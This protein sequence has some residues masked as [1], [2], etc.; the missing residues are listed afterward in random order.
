[1]STNQNKDLS[2]QPSGASN[3]EGTIAQRDVQSTTST[4]IIKGDAMR[5]AI[6][7]MLVIPSTA[8]A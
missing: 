4:W 2:V 5:L 6:M 7:A 1:M 3:A 8:L